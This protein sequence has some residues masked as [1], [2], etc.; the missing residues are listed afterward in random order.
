MGQGDSER[1]AIYE[2]NER[3]MLLDLTL[4]RVRKRRL[5][6]TH[7][8]VF[9]TAEETASVGVLKTA[10]LRQLSRKG[11][12]GAERASRPRRQSED[13]QM[14]ESG[15]CTEITKRIFQMRVHRRMVHSVHT[16]SV[17]LRIQTDNFIVWIAMIIPAMLGDAQC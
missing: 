1:S 6:E 16:L 4:N 15:N 12:H 17:C 5:I 2:S 7:V 9:V 8:S 10:C 13:P 11:D 3:Q 14:R